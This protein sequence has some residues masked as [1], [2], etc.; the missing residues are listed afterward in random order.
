MKKIM[1]IPAS[2]EYDGTYQTKED[3][4]TIIKAVSTVKGWPAIVLTRELD[5]WKDRF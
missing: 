5:S 3:G 1:N 4:M 2:K